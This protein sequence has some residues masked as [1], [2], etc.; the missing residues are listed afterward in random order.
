MTG[1]YGETRDELESKLQIWLEWLEDNPDD[2]E[3]LEQI[4]YLRS[5]LE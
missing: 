3:A 5:C 1:E 4:E 2:E